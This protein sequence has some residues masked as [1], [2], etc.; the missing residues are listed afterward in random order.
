MI[1][2]TYTLQTV[3]TGARSCS[4]TYGQLTGIA[5]DADL[6]WNDIVFHDEL[7]NS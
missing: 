3:S 6:F 1:A 5:N 2:G 4:R 7:H